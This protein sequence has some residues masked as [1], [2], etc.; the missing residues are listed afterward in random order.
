L[1][2]IFYLFLFL[3]DKKLKL[4][5]KALKSNFFI[6]PRYFGSFYKQYKKLNLSKKDNVFFQTARRKDMALI[7][8]LIKI[9]KNHPKFHI[10]VMLP[11]KVKFKGFFY[12]LNQLK[13]EM[14]NKKIFIY[15][16]S[17]YNY[18]YFLKNSVSKKGIYKSNI[19]WSFFK[20]K[21]K[22][23]RHVIGF[24]GDARKSRGFHLLPKLIK[25]L[26]NKKYKFDY[27]IQYSKISNDLLDTKNELINLSKNDKSIYLLEKY[28]DYKEFRN[29]LKKID[30]MP[31]IH[32]ASEINKITSGTMYSCLSHEIPTV[33]PK[34]TNFMNDII[35]FKSY[36]KAENLEAFA[37]KI[38]KISKNYKFY[39][40]NVKLNSL[41]LKKILQN[42]PLKKFII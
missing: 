5:I 23:K 12:Y 35:K 2:I 21:Y 30:I 26:K 8:F 42:D 37:K 24:M 41:K 3:K 38:N 13:Y 29:I 15:T 4:F 32:K 20:R 11:P 18:K 36:E 17:N 33:V 7:N 22:K 40:K 14:D 39:L 31:I 6:L 1:E 27:I 25:L 19:P 34:G 28:C 16:W 9:D 10:R